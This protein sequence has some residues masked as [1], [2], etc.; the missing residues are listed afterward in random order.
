MN[1]QA[2]HIEK[3]GP[4]GTIFLN[5]PKA[6]N[7]LNL[8]LVGSLIQALQEVAADRKIRVVVIRGKGKAF[9]AG[10]DLKHFYQHL[11]TSHEEFRKISSS[12]N[13]IVKLISEIPKPVIAA[14]DG[15]AYAAG[16]GLALACDILV[17]THNA[18]FSPSF[19][20]IALSPNASSS[21]FLP[22][23][24]GIKRAT[25]AFFIGKVFSAVEAQQIGIVNH[26][27]SEENF[28]EELQRFAQNLAQRPTS[29]IS[30]IKKLLR[31]TFEQTL[32][33]QLELEKEE[34][35]GASTSED[36]KE[37]VSAFVEK[38]VPKFKGK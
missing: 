13:Q 31:L 9:S 34:I 21:Y 22:R 33:D 12:L 6:K 14:I 5:R 1:N 2:I 20:N 17:A 7:A 26:V 8:D 23:I 25:E 4:I 19:I 16:F 28:E 3:S 38:R 10:G 32:L 37:G 11:K 36:F 27:W 29:T 30:R 35:A 24:I 15:P 18:N